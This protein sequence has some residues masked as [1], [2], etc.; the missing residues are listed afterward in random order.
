MSWKPCS[1]LHL[2]INRVLSLVL[3]VFFR[4]FEQMRPCLSVS[5]IWGS[6]IE[7]CPAQMVVL[8][9]VS[10]HVTDDLDK[11][12][13]EPHYTNSL[14]IRTT[15]NHVVLDF[16]CVE[17]RDIR[18]SDTGFESD[19]VRQSVSWISVYSGFLASLKQTNY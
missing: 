3:T 9:T 18:F 12:R 10:N 6:R 13:I 7:P 5:F 1:K 17:S 2:R 11:I 16:F 15:S 4:V 8:H 19:R 14:W